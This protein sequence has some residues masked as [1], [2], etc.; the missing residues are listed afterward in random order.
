M[1]VD[2]N[3]AEEADRGGF[4]SAFG[5][6]GGDAIRAGCELTKGPFDYGLEGTR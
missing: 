1:E 3:G 5:E 6:G 4:G 2:E